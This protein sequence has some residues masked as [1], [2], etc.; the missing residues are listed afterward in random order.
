[1]QITSS[2]FERQM[3]RAHV[4]DNLIGTL[5]KIPA[6]LRLFLREVETAIRLGISLH[7]GMWP[8]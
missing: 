2:S 7:L 4:T 1:M 6:W 3:E 8:K 5:Q